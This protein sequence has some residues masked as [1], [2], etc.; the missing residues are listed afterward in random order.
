MF[1]IIDI[2]TCGNSFQLRKGRIIEISILVYD[3]LSVVD[4]FTT[5][6]NPEC[7]ISPFYT[8]VS[9]ITNEMVENAPKFHEVAADIL[10]YTENCV[11]VA[12]NVG[13][14][15]GFV[16]EE[17]ASLGYLYRRETLCTVRLSR[18]LIPGKVSYSLGKLCASLDIP[19][20]NRHR[21][22]GDATATAILFDLLLRIKSEHPQYR[23]MDVGEIMAR[24]IDKIKEYI[25][26]KLPEECGV[27]YFLNEDGEIIYIGKSKNMYTRAKAHFTADLKKSRKILAE[28]HQVDFQVTGSEIIALLLEAAEIKKHQ[29]KHNRRTKATEFTH[30]IDWS[31][32][33]S[34]ILELK[35]VAADESNQSL[36]LFPSY[37]SARTRL[38]GLIEEYELC[39]AYCGLT[40]QDS[41][42]FNHQIK[43]CR[44]ICAGAEEMLIYNRRVQSIIN[45]HSYPDQHFCFIDK[46]R[47][48]DERSIVLV[49]NRKFSGYGYIDEFASIA[50]VEDI[51]NYLKNS[52]WHP[53]MDD[54]LR[55]WLKKNKIRTHKLPN[56]P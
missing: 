56:S 28:L 19:I 39:M 50:S 17:F 29:P 41:V 34:G 33:E 11:F 35:I 23:R 15:Y 38:D 21:A 24:K 30:S 43:K 53:D 9:G 25:L 52:S 48:P 47:E 20:E 16:R 51:K 40:E 42:C 13:F 22:E 36:L 18:K 55:S 46:G 49:E 44:G 4:K 12:H 37:F 2:E 7:Y 14:D 54:L 10:R 5:L 27:Y 32:T 31:T 8:S 26:K 45:L 3:G 1:A 6:I